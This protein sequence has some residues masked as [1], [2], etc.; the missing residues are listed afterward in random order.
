[1]SKPTYLVGKVQ[2]AQIFIQG[3][4]CKA[5]PSL[6]AAEGTADSALVSGLS[7]SAV[8]D[9]WVNALGKHVVKQLIYVPGFLK[10]HPRTQRKRWMPL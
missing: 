6:R 1:M 4:Q 8:M 10:Q 9:H 7:S 2:S 3:K 5:R